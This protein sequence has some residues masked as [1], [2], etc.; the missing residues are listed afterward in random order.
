MKVLVI[1]IET[2][3]LCEKKDYIVEIAGVILNTMN[4][5]IKNKFNY[6]VNENSNY[7]R[8][9]WI[10]SNSDLT[11]T[12]VKTK[13]LTWKEIGP[14]LQKLFD[15]YIVTCYNHS[16]DFRFLESRGFNFENRLK[17]PMLILTNVLK[18]DHDY[19]K[20]YKWPS[21]QEVINY[22]EWNISE[23]HR[24]LE[25]SRIEAKIIFETMKRGLWY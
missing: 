3:G 9:A 4:G 17:D 22:F 20:K 5:K 6:L 21:V 23:P 10:Y 18:I 2:T 16:F 14:K 12:E 24:A 11:F 7:E 25:D 15:K 8:Y 13:G 1:D 19:F